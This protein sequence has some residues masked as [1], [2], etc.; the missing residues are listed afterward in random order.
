MIIMKTITITSTMT[1]NS[2]HRNHTTMMHTMMNT[3]AMRVVKRLLK[4][5]SIQRVAVGTTGRLHLPSTV[6]IIQITATRTRVSQHTTISN[7]LIQRTMHR[8]NTSSRTVV[9]P[10]TLE[11]RHAAMVC[12]DRITIPSKRDLVEPRK[13]FTKR[14]HIH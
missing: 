10:M 14:T 12:K 11:P 4:N 13:I 3:T 6:P 9:M 1:S 5:H 8:I 2:S 7:Q